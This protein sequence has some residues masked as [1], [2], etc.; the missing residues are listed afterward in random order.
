M[1]DKKLLPILI[2][3]PVIF[4]LTSLI[5]TTFAIPCPATE[6]CNW[7]Y[8]GTAE[9]ELGCDYAVVQNLDATTAD[10]LGALGTEHSV[11]PSSCVESSTA[12]GLVS[13]DMP[14]TANDTVS[15]TRLPP[16]PDCTCTATNVHH[17]NVDSVLVPVSSNH[18]DLASLSGWYWCAAYDN[19]APSG[20]TDFDQRQDGWWKDPDYRVPWTFCVPTA[21]ANCF[22]WIDSKY[23]DPTGVLG[24]GI[25]TFPLVRDYGGGSPPVPGP[26]WDD[27]NLSNV[28]DLATPWPPEGPPPATPGFVPGPQPQ[29]SGMPAWGELIERLAWYMDCDG[30]RYGGSFRGTYRHA[31][32]G[33]IRQWLEEEGLNHMLGVTSVS[34][35]DFYHIAE[36][37]ERGDCVMLSVGWWDEEESGEWVRTSGHLVT[38][39]GVNTDEMLIAL[40]DSGFDQTPPINSQEH[41]DAAIV[42]HD[43]WP[44][45]LHCSRP[46]G[47][48][49]LRDYATELAASLGKYVISQAVVEHAVIIF[50]VPPSVATQHASAIGTTSVSLNMRYTHGDQ[51]TIDLRYA[52][53]KADDTDWTGAPWISASIPWVFLAGEGIHEETLG[54]LSSNTAYEFRA[55][56]RYDGVVIQG[57]VLTFTTEKIEP[58]VTTG[59]A[60]DITT[61]SAALS[62]DYTVGDYRP[63]EVRFRWRESDTDPWSETAWTPQESDGMHVGAL[64]GLDPD[65]VY[66]FKAQLTYDYPPLVIEGGVSTL[67]TRA[68][69]RCFIATAAYGTPRAAEVQILREFRDGYL[70]T[71]PVGQ[72]FV[73]FY[74]SVSPPIAEFITQHPGLRPIVRAGLVPAV[75]MSTAVVNTTPAEKMAI[76]GSQV[77]VSVAL[78]VWWARRRSKGPQ[79]S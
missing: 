65:T 47:T 55:E 31:M 3:I 54:G 46:T 69:G 63:V 4:G 56:V 75:A 26:N 24:D 22:W 2:A 9:D 6:M 36:A 12:S 25:D 29:P 44:V 40:S 11:A 42:S 28:N 76:V 38:V 67:T 30:V 18:S 78:A 68:K 59:E 23:A 74:Y 77:L 13:P 48:W 8:L 35:P 1:K 34:K 21:V 50:S 16:R 51:T 49:W 62:M 57:E 73:D 60:T 52:Y 20:M 71:N 32:L 5:S 41:N 15:V 7:N 10:A 53:K 64:S 27:H 19:Y 14:T 79:Y 70:L 45:D 61:D 66:E 58:I 43:I 33:G 17:L 72:A 39:A 37:V